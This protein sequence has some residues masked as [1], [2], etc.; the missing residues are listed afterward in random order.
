MKKL[1]AFGR[2][3]KPKSIALDTLFILLHNKRLHPVWPN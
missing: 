1:K 2:S 3:I